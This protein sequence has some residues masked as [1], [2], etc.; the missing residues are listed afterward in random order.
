[1][2]LKKQF[3]FASLLGELKKY[4]YNIKPTDDTL[5]FYLTKGIGLRLSLVDDEHMVL[6]EVPLI[7]GDF[8]CYLD[9]NDK[10]NVNEIIA[11]L[12]EYSVNTL[13]SIVANTKLEEKTYELQQ[14]N[15]S[16][17]LSLKDLEQ[18]W[19]DTGGICPLCESEVK[20]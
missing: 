19:E 1:M 14:T 10:R 17:D 4:T 7:N 20:K 2:R 18:A 12:Y 3:V 15:I 8:S 9:G 13:K 5:D 11:D 16:F 6:E